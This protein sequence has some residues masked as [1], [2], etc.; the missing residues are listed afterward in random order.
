MKK[1][2]SAILAAIVIAT[3][4]CA[5]INAASEQVV[6]T[7]KIHRVNTWAKQNNTQVVWVSTPMRN[8]SLT[9]ASNN[10]ADSR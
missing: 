4:G 3:A 6:D 5:S 2:T 9:A 7:E 10:N 8:L 1:V